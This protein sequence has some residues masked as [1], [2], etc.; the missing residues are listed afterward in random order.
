[1]SI[2]LDK[3]IIKESHFFVKNH[4]VDRINVENLNL[5]LKIFLMLLNFFII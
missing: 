1:M 2:A 4:N 5:Q 3:F